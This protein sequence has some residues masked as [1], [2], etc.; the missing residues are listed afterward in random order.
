[1]LLWLTP[2]LDQRAVH[3]EVLA[4]QQS[5]LL[6]HLHRR[7]EQLG[8]RVV[9]DE[10]VAVLAE[11]RVV[12][13][14]VLDGQAHEPAEQQVV[15]NLLDELPLAAYAVEHLQQ[16]GPHE[17][18]RSDARAAALHFGLVHRRELRVHLRQRVV[19]PLPD[20]S[21]WML[22][23]HEVL[24]L[25]RREQALVVTVGASH[26]RLTSGRSVHR[27]SPTR[28]VRANGISTAC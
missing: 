27:S 11:H 6:G 23:R 12:P 15:L 18:L 14:A 21:Q 28:P 20:R 26:R 24:E 4:R 13:H 5:A 25:A 17:L 9:L 19:D 3:A 8:H 22:G 10:P 2:G 7:V 1:M 16:H